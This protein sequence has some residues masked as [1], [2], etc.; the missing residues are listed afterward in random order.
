MCDLAVMCVGRMSALHTKRYD[1][2]PGLSK[3][4]ANFD[5]R[6]LTVVC[7]STSGSLHVWTK[8]CPCLVL[9]LVSANAAQSVGTCCQT[10][11]NNPFSNPRLLGAQLHQKLQTSNSKWLAM[12]HD[13]YQLRS[14]QLI[15]SGRNS[16][17]VCEGFTCNASTLWQGSTLC[18]TGSS[19]LNHASQPAYSR[20]R[21]EY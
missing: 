21:E 15:T 12:P 13:L 6:G 19:V 10:A 14:G 2:M 8:H 4:F 7:P 18:L 16:P 9:S 1:R 11:L 5:R 20:N 17:T 3:G